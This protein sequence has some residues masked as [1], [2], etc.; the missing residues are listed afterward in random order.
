MKNKHGPIVIVN[1]KTY[2]EATGKKAME[3]SKT[4]EQ[5]QKETGIH[6]V[7]APQ[8]TDI[9]LISRHV[10]IPVFAQHIDPQPQGAHTGH[11]CA[12]AV[13]ESGAQGTLLNHSERQ[14][15]LPAMEQCI[16]RARAV[17]M[18][19]VVCAN[20]AVTSSA[21]AALEPDMIAVEPPELIGTGIAVSKA[22][23][24]V[25]TDTVAK[26]RSINADV[27]ILCGAGISA[28]DDV[29]SALR[30]GAQGILVSSA[31]VKAE[32]QKK[33]ASVFANALL[34]HQQ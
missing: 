19:S 12:E 8:A 18:T 13:K 27:V 21:C 26:I 31:I 10:E 15:G 9:F 11:N 25:I 32:N 33:V 17:G 2:P 23:P 7:V 6:M 28:S 16:R 4:L 1:F 24:E 5:V 3:L 20:N 30:L 22:R 14:L 34:P 29:S